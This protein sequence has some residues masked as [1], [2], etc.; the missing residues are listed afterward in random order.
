MTVLSPQGPTHLRYLPFRL[1]IGLLLV[2]G[3]PLIHLHLLHRLDIRLLLQHL[4]SV[5]HLLVGSHI[6]TELGGMIGGL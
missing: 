3:L 6:A 1:Y 5:V 4:Y 2:Q